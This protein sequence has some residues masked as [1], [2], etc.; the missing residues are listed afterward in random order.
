MFQHFGNGAVS[1]AANLPSAETVCFSTSGMVRFLL[2]QTYPVLKL[3]VSPIHIDPYDPAIPISA[4]PEYAAELADRIGLYHTIGMPEETWSLNENQ[5]TDAD[6]LAVIRTTLAERE[7][8]WYSELEAHTADLAVTVF[9]QTD[10]VSHMFYRGL[11]EEHPLY[12][13]SGEDARGAIQWIY[14]EADRVLGETLKRMDG[15]DKLMVLSDH[16]FAPFRK[17]VHLNRWL[18]DAG[19]LVFR[20]G[21]A[22]TDSLFDGVDWAQTQAYALGLNGIF[23]NQQGREPKGSVSVLETQALKARIGEQ[24]IRAVDPETGD[25]LVRQVFD[26]QDIYPGLAISEA[27]DLVVGYEKNYRAA[28]QTTLG[29]T[30]QERGARSCI[31]GVFRVHAV[32]GTPALGCVRGTGVAGQYPD[33]GADDVHQQSADDGADVFLCLPLRGLVA[34]RRAEAL[35]HGD[36][37]RLGNADLRD[38]LAADAARVPAAGLGCGA[39]FLR[40]ARPHLAQLTRPVQEPQATATAGP[41]NLS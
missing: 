19:Y 25:S 29:G 7:A 11:D 27:P 32:S 30:P 36:V 33:R 31:G 9:V 3:Y 38:H 22:G 24:L 12:G 37:V 8:M 23:I 18:A 41:G 34:R 6:Y 26:R 40:H 39:R 14:Q 20:P 28:W 10:R 21:E 2:L 4:P 17:A 5:I 35:R 15:H 13:E 16:G 1:P